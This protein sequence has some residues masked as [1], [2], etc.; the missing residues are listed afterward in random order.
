MYTLQK[1]P[2]KKLLGKGN[3]LFKKIHVVYECCEKSIQTCK[4]RFDH[5]IQCNGF[6]TAMIEN[7][8]N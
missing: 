4:F 7:V 3:Y 2:V 5:V 6:M 8:Y 1:L